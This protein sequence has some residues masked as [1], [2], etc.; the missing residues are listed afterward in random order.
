MTGH[1]TESPGSCVSVHESIGVT[2]V[3]V[4]FLKLLIIKVYNRLIRNLNTLP[5]MSGNVESTKKWRIFLTETGHFAILPK[6]AAVWLVTGDMERAWMEVVVAKS[7]Y[8][9]S[10]CLVN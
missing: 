6:T 3:V 9:R 8:Y 4:D 5:K 1:C 10:I 2:R 7:M